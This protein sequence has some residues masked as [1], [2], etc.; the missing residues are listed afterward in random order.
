MKRIKRINSHAG[1]A[2][3]L[4]TLDDHDFTRTIPRDPS[5]PRPYA[6]SQE[7]TVYTDPQSRYV[8]IVETAHKQY[9]VFQVDDYSLIQHATR[10]GCQNGRSEAEQGADAITP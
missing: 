10:D 7:W 1:L 4:A 3:Y 9:D 2:R 6:Y 5:I 8:V